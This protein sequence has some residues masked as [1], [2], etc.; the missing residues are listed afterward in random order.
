MKKI[1]AMKM[2][3]CR[4]YIK[5][6]LSVTF[7]WLTFA[8]I[9]QESLSLSDALQ[10]ALES[11]YG[12]VVS[13]SDVKI[14]ELNNSWGKAGRYP[15]IGF[16]ATSTN[17]NELID[18]ST[19]NR[20]NGGIGINWTLFNGFRVNITKSKLEKLENI[21]KGSSAVVV[22]NTI[23][24][25]VMSY[26][27]ILLQNERLK[28]L[29]KVMKLSGDRYNYEEKKRELGSSVTYNVLL[30]KNIYLED[31]ASF[32]NQEAIV[33]NAIRNL[34]FLLGEQPTK[35]WN[36]TEDFSSDTVDYALG[37]LLDKML[38]NNQTLQNQYVNLMLQQDEIKYQKG[39]L[40]P[41]VSLS[42][43]MDNSYSWMSTTAQGETYNED[44]TPYG[45][46]TLSYDIFNGGN[47]KRAIDIAKINEQITQ[48]ETEEMKH[49]L[50]NQMY[51]EFETY[52]LRKVLLNVANESL[53]TAEMNLKIAE[54]K[55]KTGAIN[56][57]NYRD[58]QLNYLNSAINQIQSIYNLIYS[59]TNL[60]RLTGGFLNEE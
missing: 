26:Y 8:G 19:T 14:A 58:I 20:I 9:A 29:E 31:K 43:G 59:N 7:I 33:K 10:K 35:T 44:L 54:E 41:R 47:R 30:A 13:K 56:S 15:N 27:N 49:S 6:I 2:N 1:H 24:D 52:N 46:V 57:F 32:L 37:D 55:Y 48:I 17:S 21:A 28:V 3:K 50:T 45:N 16:N 34:N 42:A 36:F 22:E 18:N 23:Q 60:T 5:S 40:Y 4:L 38:A 51:N 53:Q 25:V 12:I 39:A 11:N